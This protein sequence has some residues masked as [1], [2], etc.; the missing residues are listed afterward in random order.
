[1]SAQAVVVGFGAPSVV[2]GSGT[3]NVLAVLSTYSVVS[4]RNRATS[5]V[6]ARVKG[7][8]AT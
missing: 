8:S 3:R 4:V 6:N 5:P 1:M 7:S 2:T